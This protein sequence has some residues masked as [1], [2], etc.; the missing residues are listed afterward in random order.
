VSCVRTATSERDRHE[1]SGGSHADV[2]D[3]I[4]FAAA[5]SAVG[6][7]CCRCSVPHRH[8]QRDNAITNNELI[9]AL[10]ETLSSVSGT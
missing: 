2:R 4:D 10:Y 3:D 7:T 6:T 1:I 5:R 8:S 9:A